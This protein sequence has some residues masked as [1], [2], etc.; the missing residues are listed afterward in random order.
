MKLENQ[1]TNVKLSNKLHELGVTE[2]SLFFRDSTKSKEED[3]EFWGKPDYCP[4]NVACYTTA[5]LGEILPE[6]LFTDKGA[7]SKDWM[8]CFARFSKFNRI[9][10]GESVDSFSLERTEANARAKLLIYVLKQKNG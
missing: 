9:S 1:V 4:D 10:D 7:E 2:P 8:G 6:G 5:E 3:I